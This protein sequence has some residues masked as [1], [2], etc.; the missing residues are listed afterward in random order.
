VVATAKR[1]LKAGE[2]LDGEGGFCVWGRQTPAE[3]SLERE[4]LPLG[5][6]QHVRL[7]RD[8]AV[9]APLTWGDVAYDPDDSAVKVRREMEAAFGRRN[10]PAAP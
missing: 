2:I 5:L 8:V 4:L 9:G 1:D 6:A 10:E 7:R 3:R